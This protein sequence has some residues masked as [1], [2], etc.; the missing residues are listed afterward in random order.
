VRFSFS[1]LNTA[2]EVDAGVNAIR[3]IAK[4]LT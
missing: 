2:D 3:Q 4:E 1:H